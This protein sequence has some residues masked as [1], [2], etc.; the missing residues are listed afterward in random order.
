MTAVSPLL[1]KLL[2]LTLLAALLYVGWTGLLVPLQAD[3]ED[4]QAA[5]E[6]DAEFLARYQAHA[7]V[8]ADV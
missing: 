6:R 5:V 4:H 3:L 7:A 1:R 8:R 2:A